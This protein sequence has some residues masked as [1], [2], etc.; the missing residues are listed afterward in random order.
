M[1]VSRTGAK[2][3]LS[4][5]RNENKTMV[6]NLRFSLSAVEGIKRES[7]MVSFTCLKHYS[8]CFMING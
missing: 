1:K 6:M 4:F 8:G 3:R 7:R 2:D 5:L